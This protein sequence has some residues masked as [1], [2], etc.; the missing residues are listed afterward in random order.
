M[1]AWRG[2]YPVHRQPRW[3]GSRNV[4]RGPVPLMAWSIRERHFGDFLTLWCGDQAV[5]THLK[6]VCISR[7]S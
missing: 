6:E 5:A 4:G 7:C 1:L 2:P 3:E